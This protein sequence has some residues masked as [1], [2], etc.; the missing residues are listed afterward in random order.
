MQ[1]DSMRK[2]ATP[3]LFARGD[4]GFIAFVGTMD[5]QL[6]DEGTYYVVEVDGRPVASGGWSR[7]R[8]NYVGDAAGGSDG[9]QDPQRLRPSRLGAPRLRAAADG[10]CRTGSPRRR[11]RAASS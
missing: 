11:L 2:L 10:A 7:M 6:I 5:D 3:L 9:R 1:I 4:R 8:G